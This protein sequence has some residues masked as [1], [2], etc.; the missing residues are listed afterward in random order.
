VAQLAPYAKGIAAWVVAQVGGLGQALLQFIVTVA[1]ATLMYAHGEHLAHLARRCGRRLGAEPG[2]AAVVLCGQAIRGVALGVGGTALAQAA[3]AG[4]GLL[5]LDVPYAGLMT[6]AVLLL[7]LA[8]IGPLP[9]MLPAVGW[10]YWA[11]HPW[12]ATLLLVWT[13]VV[14]TMDIVLRPLLIR[15]GADL[16]LV[17]IF[18]G[19]V[20]G[21]LAFGIVGIFIGPVVLAVTYTLFQ[22][23]LRAPVSPGH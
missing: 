11:D 15:R 21:L 13:T 4:L 6:A 20:G 2:E 18:G 10:L 1:I 14:G 22:A 17:L 7:C 23:W 12:M 3:A 19:V 5:V 16:P 9:V 8:Q